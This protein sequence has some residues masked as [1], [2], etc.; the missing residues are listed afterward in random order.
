MKRWMFIALAGVAFSCGG[1]NSTAPIVAADDGGMI[2]DGTSDIGM[3][4][5]IQVR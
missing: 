2:S 5:A 4:G 1:T 3:Y